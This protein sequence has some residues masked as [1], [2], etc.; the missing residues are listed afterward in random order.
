M[1]KNIFA[2]YNKVNPPSTLKYNGIEYNGIED[3]LDYNITSYETNEVTNN[4]VTSDQNPVQQIRTRKQTVR[5]TPPQQTLK[6]S[7]QFEKDY[8]QAI[9]EDSSTSKY[10]NLLT[11]LAKIESSYN[12]AAHNPAGAYGYF[13][14]FESGKV[15]NVSN[16]G[17]TDTKTFLNNPVLQ[18][19]AA[20][21]LAQANEKQLTQSRL[22]KGKKAGLSKDDMMAIM[23]F[24]GAGGLDA[25]LKGE[26]RSDGANNTLQYLR[27]FRNA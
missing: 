25:F 12:S 6:G 22:E 15:R 14:L 16:Y 8:A 27:K 5:K 13:Q 23:W 26:Y 4:E 3:P 7:S 11:R 9:K 1:Y 18:I 2:T 17:G 19:K 21:K 24:S 20:S 10:K